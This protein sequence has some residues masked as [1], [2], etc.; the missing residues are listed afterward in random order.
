[1]FEEKGDFEYPKGGVRVPIRF[2]MSDLDRLYLDVGSLDLK[3][4]P[5]YNEEEKEE[6]K[7]K[8]VSEQ[9]VKGKG[10]KPNQLF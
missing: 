10:R 9:G 4:E 3:V 6:K 2:E 8:K 7:D 1:M 5:E